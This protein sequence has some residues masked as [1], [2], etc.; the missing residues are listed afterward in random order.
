MVV[1]KGGA[2]FVGCCVLRV[3]CCELCDACCVLYVVCCGLLVA[4]FC[5]MLFDG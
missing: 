2:L 4:V 1:V 5:R 3:V